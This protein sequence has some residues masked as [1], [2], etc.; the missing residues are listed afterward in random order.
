MWKRFLKRQCIIVQ[1]QKFILPL[2]EQECYWNVCGDAVGEV[3]HRIREAFVHNFRHCSYRW[4]FMCRILGL[5]PKLHWLLM[6]KQTIFYHPWTHILRSG[7]NIYSEQWNPGDKKGRG[8]QGEY[9]NHSCFQPFLQISR[10]YQ[11]IFMQAVRMRKESP[12]PV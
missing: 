2:F 4:V 9:Q 11:K 8:I 5:F 3:A 10:K 7:N 12:N 6:P 1:C